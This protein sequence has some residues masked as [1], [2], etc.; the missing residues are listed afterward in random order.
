MENHT[1][2]QASRNIPC[3]IIYTFPSKNTKNLS[4]RT[5][6]NWTGLPV[7]HGANTEASVD[8]Y[9]AKIDRPK[10]K[11]KQYLN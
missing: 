1:L 11:V 3:Q 8:F 4:S 5:F 7:I 2:T 6:L 10:P 9:D